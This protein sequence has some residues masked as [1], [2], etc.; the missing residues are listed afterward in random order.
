MSLFKPA[1]DRPGESTG[2]GNAVPVT[3]FDITRRYDIYCDVVH[4]Q[5]LYANVRVVGM[6]T[7]DTPTRFSSGA[8][9]AL[10]EIEAANGARM[11]IPQFGIKMICEHGTE[12]TFKV[13][14]RLRP[15]GDGDSWKN[16][17]GE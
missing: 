3:P 8:I 14:S 6:R 4:E 15:P 10:L 2:S 16:D 7:F 5:R 13:L 17:S 9:G 12:P 1:K 11:M